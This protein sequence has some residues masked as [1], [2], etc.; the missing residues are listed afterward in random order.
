[1]CKLGP[2]TVLFFTGPLPHS[3]IHV[4]IFPSRLCMKMLSFLFVRAWA[5]PHMSY[6]SWGIPFP[7]WT[8]DYIS[9]IGKTNFLGRDRDREIRLI[10]TH[11]ETET[12][13]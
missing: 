3:N 9:L 10:K 7:I 11:Y 6:L 13:K 1:M 12:E 2:G 8:P 5:M 4:K